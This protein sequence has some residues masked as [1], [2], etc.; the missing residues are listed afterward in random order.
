[1]THGHGYR[2]RV[3]GTTQAL[4]PDGTEAPLAGPRL[5]A[6][7][8][9]LAA[10]AGRTVPV[11]GLAAQVWPD[12]DPADALPADET[13]ALQALVGRLRRALGR[14]AVRSEPGGYRLVAQPDDIDLFR[15]ERLAADGAAALAAGDPAAATRLLDEALGLWRGPALADL[16][17]RDRD[18]LAVRARLRHT[19]ARRDRLAAEV[20]LGRPQDALPGLAEI[21]ADRPLD[22]P[23]AAL[24][25]R[26]LRAAGRPAE[27][28]QA[29]DEV[30]AVLAAR[31]GTAPGP[32]LRALHA[33]LLAA[34]DEPRREPEREPAP[35]REPDPKRDPRRGSHPPAPPGNLRARLT[36]F[37]GR[38]TELA[39]LVEEIRHHRLVTLLGPGG[40]GKTRLALETA[41]STAWPDG[42]W[43]AELA[44][45]RDQDAVVETVL[46]ALGAREPLRWSAD[47]RGRD[48][49]AHLLEHCGRRRLL[50]VLDNC[51]HVIGAAA[52]LA[53]TLLAACPGVTVLATSREP[54][55]VPGE[56]VRPV[57]PL[58]ED[59]ALRLL[60][61]RG[62][63]ARP[64]FDVA[65]DPD[66]CAEICRRLDGLPLAIELAAAR[67]RALT[68]RQIADRLDDRFRLLTG[69]SRT[70]L[71]RQ[72]T[73]RAVVDWSW[74][75]LDAAERA[76]LRR[77]A[78]FS[79]GC[80]L[81]LAEEVCAEPDTLE[82]LTSLVDKSLV[83]AVPANDGTMRYRLLETVADY[84]AAR[85]DEAGERETTARRHLRALRELARTGDRELRGPH[86][87]EW[88][89][90]FETEHD[91]LRAALR[92]AVELGEEQEGLCLALSLNW[93]WQLR[94]HQSDARVWSAA[95]AALGPDPFLPPVRPAVPM[96]AR[97]TEVPPP[98]D[99]E[100]LWE[101]RRGVR[102][103]VFASDGSQGTA[104]L[105]K[106][107]NRAYMRAIADAYRPGLPQ[108]SRQPGAMWF[109]VRML[110]G[111]FR[112][113]P[114]TM[115]AVVECC[116][117][118]GDDVDLGF[119]LLMRAKILPDGYADADEALARFE[120][121]GDLWGASESLSARGEAHE[122][123]GRYAEAARDFERALARAE[124]VGA[125]SQAVFQA[126][127]ASVRLRL[128]TTP[129][130][131]EGAERLLLDAAETAR[132]YSVETVST[133]RLLL[134]QH[135]GRT[136]RVP[137]ARHQLRLIEEEFTPATAE[138]FT[139]MLLGLHAWLDCLDGDHAAA[140]R[141]LARAVRLLETL[142]YVVAPHMV[143]AQ[144]ATAAWA[145]AH[146]GDPRDGARLLGAYDRHVTVASGTGFR[147]LPV[148]AEREVRDR[149]ETELRAVLDEA[150]Y[151]RAHAEGGDLTLREAAALVR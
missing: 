19:E 29:Y 7:L 93:F 144:L 44:P 60:A 39:A 142:A 94:G 137:L 114:D 45:V 110:L 143:L 149:A 77:L 121:A 139:G 122:R 14:D 38:D 67:L 61:E 124:R 32:E 46:T 72:Q 112:G 97:C 27:A 148:D 57:E 31:L 21:V 128:A 151:A 10:A 28:L 138:M 50:L 117:V 41:D 9:A 49:L 84:A 92:T 115:A 136:G 6:L 42:V 129:A 90:V 25:I 22:E 99:E 62:A 123:A 132:T 135:Y 78:V 133:A 12:D 37:I 116:R 63:A 147:H 35:D 88:L 140:R 30:R 146:H 107:E 81:P 24:R 105:E 131:R 64:G 118:H 15:F 26:A 11:T 79:G 150:A 34:D 127:L 2:Y 106:P 141:R 36:S 4:R 119:A 120:A 111:E 96:P 54:L 58:P 66:A 89:N 13:A 75:L 125:H 68:P 69:G 43:V 80:S 65:D 40:V 8:T 16:P 109:F 104:A 1:M 83:V 91:N 55:G 51:E 102:L 82:R 74:D 76:V 33:E 134:A 73:L 70:A 108:N 101:A 48:P 47:G 87:T 20:A 3:L 113:I 53:D 71:P 5:R 98:W 18:P 126:R 145:M 95:V 17:G 59:A 86:Q 85:L 130:E 52:R 100:T 23:L 103:L 56:T